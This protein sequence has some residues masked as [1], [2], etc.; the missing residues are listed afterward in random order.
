MIAYLENEFSDHEMIR[1]TVVALVLDNI[2]SA[3]TLVIEGLRVVPKYFCHVF[4]RF[5]LI[6]PVQTIRTTPV[7]NGELIVKKR[8]SN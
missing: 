5:K 3:D 7:C 1:N 8:Y 2:L 4:F 6:S